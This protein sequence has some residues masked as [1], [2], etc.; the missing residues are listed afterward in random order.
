M[1]F[2]AAQ[3]SAQRNS[4]WLVLWFALAVLSVG[5]LVYL[6][7]MLSLQYILDGDISLT[8][9][10][11]NELLF[12]VFL[13]V[14]GC[15]TVVSLFRILQISWHGGA[16]I[17]RKLGGRMVTRETNDPAEKRLLNVTEEMAIAAGIPVPVVFVLDTET[18]LNAF[19]AGLST[20]DCVIGVTRGLLE[21][22]NRDELQGIIG[23]E[24]SHIVNGDS[25]LYL[26]LAGFLFGIYALLIVG[27]KIMRAGAR[28]GDRVSV[29]SAVPFILIGL[30]LCIAGSIGFLCGRII[31]AAVSREREYLAD[32]SAVQFTRHPPG[33][34]AAL[35]KLQSCGSRIR[36]PEVTAA[37]HLF[38]GACGS[39]S[40]FLTSLFAT[41]PPLA[42]RIRRLDSHRQPLQSDK[43]FP[44]TPATAIGDSRPVSALADPH[45]AMRVA[46]SGVASMPSVGVAEEFSSTSIAQA[47][48]LLASLPESLR[49]Q[50]RQINGA[51]GIV[52]GIFF[53]SQ[54]DV[55]RRQEELLPP[56]AL[57]TAQELFQWLSAQPDHGA[58]YRLVWLD[59]VLPTLHEASE[60]QPE[61]LLSMAKAFVHADGRISAS[62][63]ALYSLLRGAL[64][65]PS[66]HRAKRGELRPEQLDRDIASL[67]G[68]IAY[69]GHEDFE[70]IH[71]AYQ[72]AMACS[73]ARVKCPLPEKT[74]LSLTAVSQALAHLALA[75]P[76]YRKRILYACS[77][78]I[79]Y[80]G[81]ITA[82]ENELL[83]AFAQSLDCPAPL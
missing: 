16:L 60:T 58:H 38:F 34:A 3:H 57:P 11:N 28:I 50:A 43:T 18:G 9:H 29:S 45:A 55:R 31:Q 1:D 44:S 61:Q 42:E 76:L 23:H 46:P 52:G 25:R 47:Q 72:A 30:P 26:K 68:L 21:A 20:Q 5:F 71:A 41:H 54:S 82:V 74:A 6:S 37:S 22:M 48:S 40:A 13:I 14:G 39:T 66:A 51:I 80:D 78:A 83:R 64:L 33:L 15:I 62:E 77:V 81:K 32:A 35:E 75:T 19:A 4:R 59:L 53:S 70:T 67:L 73:P 10:W 56:A 65:P 27:S 36:H 63:F 12:W 49:H 2:F 8:R 69:A 79:E 17:A 7:L 24:I